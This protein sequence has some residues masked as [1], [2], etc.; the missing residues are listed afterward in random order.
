MP[1]CTVVV[2]TYNDAPRLPRA[3]RSVLRQSLRDLEVIVV[4]DASTDETPR[5][6]AELMESDPRVRYLRRPANSGGCG[7]PRNDGLDAAAA[8]YLMYLDSDDELPR[9]ACKSL[10]TEIERT[11][12]D[13]VS[14]QISRLYESSG[15]LSRTIRRCSPGGGWWRASARSPS[16]SW[17][18]S[19]PTALRRA[20][21]QGRRA[22]LPRGHPLRG[23]PLLHRAVRAG[24][25]VRGRPL[26]RLP[27]AADPGGHLH[28]AQHQGD[29]QRAPPGHRRPAQR[30]HPARPRPGPPAARASVPLPHQDLRVYLN[31][32]PTRSGSG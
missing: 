30:R 8:P 2:I 17:T 20:V 11:G 5:V 12:V 14:G 26:G 28:L 10:L 15:R 29:G 24:P 16:C 3:V 32:L 19:P 13:F 27:L 7:A 22:A 25:P 1:I 4:D 18:P 23:P 6:A 9:H 21:P 31:P